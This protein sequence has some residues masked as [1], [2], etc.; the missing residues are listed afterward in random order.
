MLGNTLDENE[1]SS[2]VIFKA[3]VIVGVW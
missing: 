1:I 3:G 2:N